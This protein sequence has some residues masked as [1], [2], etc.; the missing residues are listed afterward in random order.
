VR[1]HLLYLSGWFPLRFP[2]TIWSWVLYNDAF[3]YPTWASLFNCFNVI[4]FGQLFVFLPRGCLHFL[5]AKTSLGQPFPVFNLIAI[6][7]ECVLYFFLESFLNFCGHLPHRSQPFLLISLISTLPRHLGVF[8]VQERRNPPYKRSRCMSPEL[9]SLKG[10]VYNIHIHRH[11]NIKSCA[12]AANN[13]S[14]DSLDCCKNIF[15]A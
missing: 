7:L 14:Y 6:L 8:L 5:V 1:A 11:E 12:S 2:W 13:D 3:S 4:L 15:I 10:S 9:L